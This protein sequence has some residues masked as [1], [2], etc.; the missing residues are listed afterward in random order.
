M[1]PGRHLRLSLQGS[2]E[3][4]PEK[5][6]A[7][8][9][10]RGSAHKHV[11]VC[12]G[13]WQGL[14]RL[15]TALPG[16]CCTLRDTGCSFSCS[17]WTWSPAEPPAGPGLPRGLQPGS[18]PDPSSCP[19]LVMRHTLWSGLC[20][21]CQVQLQRREPAGQ[22]REG[23]QRSNPAAPTP[24]NRRLPGAPGSLLGRPS[25]PL[26]RQAICFWVS[27]HFYCSKESWEM[28]DLPQPCHFTDAETVR[29][30]DVK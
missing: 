15:R 1:L 9:C 21:Q 8:G 17:G 6:P 20:R 19:F 13:P 18:S 5:Q 22:A 25:L 14:R 10:R 27:S 26:M 4:G 23:V 28:I 2:P 7:H 24:L 12:S 30:R 29:L 11:A 16:A 3:R